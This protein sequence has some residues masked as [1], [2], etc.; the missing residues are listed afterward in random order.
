MRLVVLLCRAD[1]FMT[2]LVL[3]GAVMLAI[4]TVSY[5]SYRASGPSEPDAVAAP[6][7]LPP[8]GEPARTPNVYWFLFDGYARQDQLAAP[9]RL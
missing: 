1:W 3:F 4:P 8:V 6:E 2:A 9:A 5:A 7:G